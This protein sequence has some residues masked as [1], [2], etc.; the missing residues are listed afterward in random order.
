MI[1]NI[2]NMTGPVPMAL[3]LAFVTAPVRAQNDS[4]P[5]VYDTHNVK[6]LKF[7]I[8]AA[9]VG[10]AAMCTNDG[11]LGGLREKG[12]NALSAHGRNRIRADDYLQFCPV[13]AVYGLDL[14][15]VKAQHR[16]VD[17][18][19]LLAM[20]YTAMNIV[21]TSMKFMSLEH[22]PDSRV[23]NSFPS[24]HTATAFMGAEFMRREYAHKSPVLAYSGYAV[25]TATG[26]LRI[27]NNRHWTNDVVPGAAIGIA[28][29]KLV[30]W[31]YP[32][33]FS[34]HSD[35]A[36]HVTMVMPAYADGGCTLTASV[37]F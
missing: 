6:P 27:Y 13:V 25:A 9:T 21:V 31:L 4:V 22:R 18:T 17:R 23:R 32:H 2:L 7:I 35:N 10:L 24:G 29:S 1:K 14:C 19:V 33:I 20:S 11:W 5:K 3:V 12:Q 26:L 30:Y 16:F 36:R 37:Q 34:R 8:P 15:G 28:S